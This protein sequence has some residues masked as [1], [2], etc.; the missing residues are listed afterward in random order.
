MYALI[1]QFSLCDIRR[2]LYQLSLARSCFPVLPISHHSPI[3]HCWEDGMDDT[4]WLE[5][6]S[7]FTAVKTL[8]GSKQLAGHIALA[9][10]GIS[11]EMIPEVLPALVSLSLED[12][13][14]RSVEQFI[15]VRRL[16]GHPVTFVGQGDIE[17]VTAP[18]NT[19]NDVLSWT[20]QDP[21]QS[22]LF[23][24]W[25]VVYRFQTDT[26]AQGKSTTTL[27]RAVR[28]NREDRVARL[29]WSPGGGLGHAVIG[30][31]VIIPMADLY[32]WRPAT[33][34]PDVVLQDPNDDVI[35]FIRPTRPTRHQMGEV[36]A[37]LHLVRSAGAGVVTHPPLMDMVT[38]TAMLYRFAS[39][40]N[41]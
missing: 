13:T 8:H 20:S 5:L 21:R 9:V 34:S 19:Q 37:E 2:Y 28:A 38:V 16:S 1:P 36:Y 25:G 15:A 10:D 33:N 29:A 24:P 14:V 18:D 23:S 11:G 7:P 27:W 4:D 26:N 12:Q 30:K 39:A 6:L 35:A 17:V 31:N 22:Q 3:V 32:R 41:L 40:F